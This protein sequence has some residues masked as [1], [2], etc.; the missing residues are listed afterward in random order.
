MLVFTFWLA[1]GTN[2]VNCPT[3]GPVSIL[4]IEARGPRALGKVPVLWG[5]WESLCIVST[6]GTCLAG[7]N[8]L[9]RG[10][11]PVLWGWWESLV[12]DGCVCW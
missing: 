9:N 5:W 11:V 12:W 8:P 10:N 7:F 1:V 4:Y 6:A 3:P 2:E